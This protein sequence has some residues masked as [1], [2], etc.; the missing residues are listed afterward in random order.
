VFFNTLSGTEPHQVGVQV[1][2]RIQG[3]DHSDAVASRRGYVFE[4]HRTLRAS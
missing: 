1:A 2:A 3:P 4:I